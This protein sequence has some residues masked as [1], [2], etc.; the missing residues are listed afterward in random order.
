MDEM[1]KNWA[2]LM[3]SLGRDEM[4]LTFSRYHTYH[5][6]PEGKVHQAVIALSDPLFV[7]GDGELTADITIL[8]KRLG[9]NHARWY[10][11][12]KYSINDRFED[13][14]DLDDTVPGS[15]EWPGCD[16]YDIIGHWEYLNSD[17]VWWKG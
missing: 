3:L 1:A 4:T 16:P 7:L 11:H 10:L 13:P 5:F 14:S 9:P 15:S 17:D 12:I 6:A 8:A 2:K